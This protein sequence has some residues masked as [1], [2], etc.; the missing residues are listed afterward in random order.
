[1]TYSYAVENKRQKH[2]T[3]LQNNTVEASPVAAS[4]IKLMDSR[5]RWIGTATELLNEL[6]PVAESLKIKTKNN[7]YWPS[8]P[9]SLS[10]RL[11]EVK[12]NLREIGIIV[13]RPV[14]TTTNTR[15][16][17]IRK[18]SPKH[19]VSPEDSNQAQL[20]LENSG[21][22]AGYNNSTS[23]D[24][25]PA[26][27]SQNC[28]QNQ[29]SGNS[30]YTGDIIHTSS[31]SSPSIHRLGHSDTF[32]CENCNLKGDIWFMGQHISPMTTTKIRLGLLRFLHY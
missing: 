24:I 2:I 26:A 10:R 12:T 6:E 8:A 4:I 31:C 30:G 22:I 7:R 25:S 11:N 19:P 1:V 21:F 20:Q 3:A 32:A 15:K 27:N 13:E 17:E 9:N 28:A 14:D 18:I 23:P 16:I 29:R 5:T